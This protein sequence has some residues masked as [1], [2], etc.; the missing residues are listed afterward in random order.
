MEAIVGSTTSNHVRGGQ[1]IDVEPNN[2]ILDQVRGTWEMKVSGA[3]TFLC[4][5]NVL[6]GSKVKAS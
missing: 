5:H 6:T 2:E 4:L 3:G 1:F